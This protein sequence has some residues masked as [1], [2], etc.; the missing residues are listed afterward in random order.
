M[1]TSRPPPWRIKIRPVNRWLPGVARVATISL[2][3]FLAVFVSLRVAGPYVISTGLVRSGME[4]SLSRWTGY[5]AEISGRPVIEFWPTPRITINKITVRQKD[6]D[7][8]LFGTIESISA[9]FSLID[10]FR[11]KASFHDFNIL[12][13]NLLLTRERDGT[14][15]WTDEGQLAQAIIGAREQN[16]EET[17]DAALDAD[18]GTIT[19]EDGTLDVADVASGKTYRFDSVTADI[20]WP[21]LSS[22]LTAVLIARMNGLDIKLDF[23]SRS[24]LLAFGGKNAPL[25]AALT[26]TLVTAKFDGVANI[27]R[28]FNL[29][30]SM[31]LGIPDLPALLTWAGQALPDAATLKAFSIDSDV[32]SA[33]NGF[34]FDNV[35]LGMNGSSAR[36]AMDVSFMPGKRPKLGGT[37][38][39]DQ[40]NFKS[41]FDAFVVRLAAGEDRGAPEGGALQA[42]DIDLR[43]SARQADLVPFKLSNVGASIIVSSNE[44]RFD[45]GDSQFEGGALTAY[46]A[47]KRG[48]FDGGG[49][50]Q[51]SIRGADFAGLIERLNLQGPLP[52][53]TGSLDLAVST[54]LPIWKA[55]PAD[56][57]G[58]IRFRAQAGSLPGFDS[59]AVRSEAAKA[60]FFSLNAVSHR[61]FAF[62]RFDIEAD[63]DDGAAQIRRGLIEGPKET[64]TLSGVIPYKSGGLALS[65]KIAATDPANDAAFPALPFFVGGSWPDP[66]LS[67]LPGNQQKQQQQGAT[68]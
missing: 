44:A 2:L 15:D 35:S 12:R 11:G 37:L 27:A 49:K 68:K 51:M 33:A 45:I 42:L 30:G 40:I 55:G 9:E 1:G 62:D 54:A 41:L 22:P 24:P 3:V 58:N 66:V 21:R 20:G 4:D 65:G 28:L 56:V 50:L 48:D 64:I 38:A 14:I 25:K 23:S 46:I 6:G 43:L 39:F 13:P 17:L 18:I 10:A 34:R 7:N 61:A 52:L 36:G 57:T 60:D 47:A 63:L 29:Q 19:V 32:I 26:S 5:S 16:G 31:S 53:T 8:K 59:D 67:A